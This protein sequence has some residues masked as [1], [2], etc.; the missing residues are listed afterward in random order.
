MMWK[1]KVMEFRTFKVTGEYLGWIVRDHKE[2]DRKIRKIANR[3]PDLYAHILKSVK[4]L[5]LHVNIGQGIF[6]MKEASK[7]VD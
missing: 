6:S 2:K 7:L 5:V 1:E 3:I 4:I